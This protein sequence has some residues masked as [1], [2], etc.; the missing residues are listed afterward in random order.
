MTAIS[1]TSGIWVSRWF[2]STHHLRSN[3]TSIG[4]PNY[5]QQ[6]TIAAERLVKLIG[7]TG[8]VA[9]MQGYPTHQ[10]TKNVRIQMAV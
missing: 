8:K 2:Y 4:K 3:I 6:G 7:R 1:N 10:T 5:S 9:V